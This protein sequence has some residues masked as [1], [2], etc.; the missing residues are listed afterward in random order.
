MRT[1]FGKCIAIAMMAAIALAWQSPPV[2]AAEHASDV[3]D[4]RRAAK[5]DAQDATRAV[6]DAMD[7]AEMAT[8]MATLARDAATAAKNAA[9]RID[10]AD[11]SPADTRAAENAAEDA[12]E[13]AGEA[14]DKAGME[15]T[16]MVTVAEVE[17]ME[18]MGSPSTEDSAWGQYKQAQVKAGTEKYIAKIP[19]ISG[20]GNAAAAATELFYC[21]C[22]C[23]SW[24]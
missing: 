17:V 18:V 2:Q 16:P 20:H 12:D 10:A 21:G 8:D 19:G 24:Q 6:K 22:W 7:Q 9:E 14:E 13:A 3:R 1:I 11:A 5:T 23:R 4:A 15:G